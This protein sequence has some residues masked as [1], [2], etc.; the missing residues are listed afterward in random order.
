[1]TPAAGP[2]GDVGRD[3]IILAVAA[4]FGLL[5]GLAQAWAGKDAADPPASLLRAAVIGAIAATGAMWVHAQ[6]ATPEIVGQSL[7]AGYFGRAVLALL[8]ARVTSAL[9]H[10][11]RQR[12]V[13]VAEDAIK[14]AEAGPPRATAA[15]A[16]AVGAHPKV[17]ALR[18]RLADVATA[19]HAS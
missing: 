18:A 8:Q 19:R 15:D 4:V 5:G 6:S 12:A 9:E 14:L 16:D 17:T 2:T 10:D 11:A 3:A 1:V 7:L 13:A